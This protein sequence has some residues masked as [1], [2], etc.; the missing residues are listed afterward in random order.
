[1][2]FS[3]TIPA[4][5]TLVTICAVLIL[6]GSRTA[7]AVSETDRPIAVIGSI[8]VT[9]KAFKAEMEKVGFGL[10]GR[11][12]KP[13]Q[14]EA[15]LEDMVRAEVLYATALSDGYDKK[16]TILDALKRI[17]INQYR[18]D[19]LEPELSKITVTE[20]EIRLFYNE[21]TSE[22][23]TP[24]MLRAAVIKISVPAKASD[25]K[26]AEL[27]K[28]AEDARAEAMTL[29]RATLSFGAV[30]V[31]YSDDQVS[32]YRGGDTGLIKQGIADARW[33]KEV[34][35][36]IF[37]L[38]EPGQVSSVIVSPGGYYIVKLMET[39]QS[40]TRP[41][42]EVKEM[43]QSRLFFEKKV[44]KEKEFYRKLATPLKVEIN[45][46]LLGKIQPPE[47]G[48]RPAPPAMPR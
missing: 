24:Q 3:R 41:L 15:L 22:F 44:Q 20:D 30:A 10:P 18:Q 29:D 19:Y 31:K 14:R 26:R 35:D 42:A 25:E 7:A 13:E 27:L 21:H 28:R 4:G 11:F 16:P 23:S 37:S 38:I 48:A 12:E 2:K 39:K 8:N 47:A 1:M 45:R 6:W 34:M 5:I 9:E 32:R 36:A 17:I 40:V 33:G 43:I 46:E